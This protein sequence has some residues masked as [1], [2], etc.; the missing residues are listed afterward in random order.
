MHGSM[1]TNCGVQVDAP[2]VEVNAV[3][4]TLGAKPLPYPVAG[5]VNGH[6]QCYGALDEPV[7][8]GRVDAVAAEPGVVEAGPLGDARDALLR[9]REVGPAPACLEYDKVPIR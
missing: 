9:S 2:A 5:A 3:R 1:G 4:A 8:A 7:F 6:M